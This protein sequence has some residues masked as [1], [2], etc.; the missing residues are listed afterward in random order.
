MLL[1]FPGM[2]FKALDFCVS[3]VAGVTI[4]GISESDDTGTGGLAFS[5]AITSAMS[6]VRT[7]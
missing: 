3:K 6:V 2:D 7:S 1:K 5:T 4:S